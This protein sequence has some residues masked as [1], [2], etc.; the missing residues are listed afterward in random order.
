MHWL[1]LAVHVESQPVRQFNL[2]KYIQPMYLWSFGS[3]SSDAV[4][5]TKEIRN[6]DKF[7]NDDAM[8][9]DC[10]ITT[11]MTGLYIPASVEEIEDDAFYGCTA[12]KRV[13]PS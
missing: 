4:L 13:H 10:D 2:D 6:F 7:G 5:G 11:Q 1:N 12:L 3:D 8:D 9:F